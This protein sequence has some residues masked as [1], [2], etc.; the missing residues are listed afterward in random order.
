MPSPISTTTHLFLVRL[1]PEVTTKSRPVRAR[2]QERLK[3]NIEQAL[4]AAEIEHRVRREWSRLFVEAESQGASEVLSRVFGI[5]SF[6]AIRRRCP[7]T[8]EEIVR[9]GAEEFADDVRGKTFAV[10]ARRSGELPFR[11]QEIHVQLGRAL[12]EHAEVDLERPDVTVHVEVR[13]DSAY[14]FSGQTRGAGGLPLGT[15]GRAVALI[16]GGF[17]SAVAAWL[18]LKRGVRVDYVLCNLA[19]ASFERNVLGV[20]KVLADSWSYGTCPVLHAV[21]F[22][23]LLQSLRQNVTPKFVQVVLKRLMYR[24]GQRVAQELGADA[25]ITGE[26]VGQVSSQT[27]P[28]LRVIEDVAELPILR[29][30]IGMD[31]EEII[32]RTRHIG[33]YALSSQIQEYCA[34]VPDKPATAARINAVRHEEAKLDLRLLDVALANR[35]MIDVTALGASELVLPYLN[36]AEVPEGAVIIDCREG[37]HYEAWHYPDALHFELDE[38]LE[39]YRTLDKSKTYVLYCPIGLQSSVAA[40]KMQTAGYQAYSFK[41]GSQALRKYA[42]EEGLD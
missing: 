34:V 3:N 27:L 28:N 21:D 29:P 18:M 6:S 12:N 36:I 42:E 20:V 10:R 40:E 5:H 13:S 9:A 30:L 8:L 31:K 14:F 35:R 37:H 41:G 25:V 24:A 7:P 33:T 2:F 4:D 39:S 1:A 22:Q 19:G 11:S 26:A 15:Q 16:S 32:D 23:P 17:D 38:L